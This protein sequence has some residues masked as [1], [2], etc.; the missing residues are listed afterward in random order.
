MHCSDL[1]GVGLWGA[2]IRVQGRLES[3]ITETYLE[4]A[5]NIHPH[6]GKTQNIL[7]RIPRIRRHQQPPLPPRRLGLVRVGRA[8]HQAPRGTRQVQEAPRHGLVHVDGHT[9][10]HRRAQGLTAGLIQAKGVGG[11]PVETNHCAAAEAVPAFARLRGGDALGV[12]LV[13]AAVSHNAERS[14]RHHSDR[15]RG[16]IEIERQRVRGHSSDGV[17]RCLQQYLCYSGISHTKTVEGHGLPDH[18]AMCRRGEHHR[19]SRSGRQRNGLGSGL[20]LHVVGALRA[21]GVHVVQSG[22]LRIIQTGHSRVLG[23]NRG[24]VV[25]PIYSGV[26][27]PLGNLRNLRARASLVAQGDVRTRA[28]PPADSLAG[29]DHHP[30]PGSSPSLGHVGYPRCRVEL[31]LLLGSRPESRSSNAGRARRPVLCGFHSAGRYDELVQAVFLQLPVVLHGDDNLPKFSTAS[32]VHHPLRCGG[33]RAHAPRLSRGAVPIRPAIDQVHHGSVDHRH[34][35]AKEHVDLLQTT[36]AH[37]HGGGTRGVNC[38]RGSADGV[39]HTGGHSSDGVEAQVM[40]HSSLHLEVV[41][42]A[43][44][45][46]GPSHHQGPVHHFECHRSLSLRRNVHQDQIPITSLHSLIKR[47][48][49]R[50]LL[51]HIPRPR[52]DRRNARHHRSRRVSRVRQRGPG[53]G[54]HLYGADHPGVQHVVYPD[55]HAVGDVQGAGADLE[56][57]GAGAGPAVVPGVVVVLGGA[58]GG[59]ASMGTSQQALRLGHVH[60]KANTHRIGLTRVATR[61][62]RRAEYRIGGR[63]GLIVAVAEAP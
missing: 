50:S 10:G 57:A 26:G 38:A 8:L 62:S 56:V 49:H 43:L 53:G 32:T 30:V 9:I 5:R 24:Q 34:L 42:G 7:R 33:H 61:L 17:T 60:V 48:K 39:A 20:D 1:D 58:L 6:V 19:G 47:D 14:P 29:H 55:V 21:R 23:V 11:G 44:G 28:R 2:A 36:G 12:A 31:E 63:H 46:C 18:Q 51:W 13:S 35:L 41:G 25:H 59:R 40:H 16:S 45:H 54:G 37:S 22:R 4:F 15:V 27:V 52:V 3:A